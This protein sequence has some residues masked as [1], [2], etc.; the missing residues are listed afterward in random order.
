M[1]AADGRGSAGRTTGEETVQRGGSGS[2]S[3]SGGSSRA[4]GRLE[5][6]DLSPLL[7]VS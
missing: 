5:R 1:E 7:V 4:G 2:S 6:H 3:S